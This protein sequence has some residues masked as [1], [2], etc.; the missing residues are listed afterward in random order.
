MFSPFGCTKKASI[1]EGEGV[2]LLRLLNVNRSQFIPHFQFILMAKF[3]AEKVLF[4]YN[5]RY[6]EIVA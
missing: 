2:H 4:W 1:Y 5:F 6:F 3:V